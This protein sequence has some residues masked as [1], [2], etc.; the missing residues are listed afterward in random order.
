MELA[1][2]VMT[3]DSMS[4][5]DQHKETYIEEAYERL[6]EL[7]ESLLALEDNTDD[8]DLVGSIFRAL[9]TIKGPYN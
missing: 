6:A 8:M 7:E 1:G 4:I 2:A 9:H 3:G 5:A